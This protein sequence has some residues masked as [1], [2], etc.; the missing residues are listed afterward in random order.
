MRVPLIDRLK[1]R[2]GE[3]SGYSDHTLES[4]DLHRFAG[5]WFEVAAFPAWF[6]KGCRCSGAELI[7]MDDYVEMH[8]ICDKEGEL[9][10]RSA[11]FE[12]VDGA[13]DVNLKVRFVW[14]FKSEYWIIA[15]DR[16]YQYAMVGHPERKYLWILSRSPDI[17]QDVYQSLL[18]KAL[19]KGYDVSK[20]VETGKSCR[21]A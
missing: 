14:P 15:L 5:R 2:T 11:D 12:V 8:S 9:S 10:V 1:K 19:S 13:P 18:K 17:D 6:E 20:L 21:A 4:V 16:D 3:A 7:H